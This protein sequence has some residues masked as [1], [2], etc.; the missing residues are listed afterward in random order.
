MSSQ[1]GADHRDGPAL[2]ARCGLYRGAGSF[3]STPQNA[4]LAAP[5]RLRLLQPCAANVAHPLETA[6]A[7]GVFNSPDSRGPPPPIK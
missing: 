7:F 3:F 6:A 1:A 5:A 2:Q 4:A